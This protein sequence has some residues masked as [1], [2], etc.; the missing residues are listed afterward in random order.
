MS[1]AFLASLLLTQYAP[2]PPTSNLSPR[3]NFNRTCAEWGLQSHACLVDTVRALDNARRKEG[4]GP[5][6]LPRNWTNLTPADQIFVITNLER[7]ARSEHPLPGLTAS[8]NRVA[9]RGAARGTDPIL[10]SPAGP[11]LSIWAEGV[12]PLA[13]DYGWMYDDGWNGPLRRTPNL[14]CT[15]ATATGCWGHRDN[16]LAEWSRRLLAG[17]PGTWYLIAGA[18]QVPT[19]TRTVLPIDRSITED[20][21]AMIVTA[22]EQPPHYV[23]TWAQ[24]VAEG[25]GSA[26][27]GW[28][29]AAV[30]RPLEEA[31]TWIRTHARDVLVGVIVVGL[32]ALTATRQGRRP[33]PKKVYRLSRFRRRRSR[34]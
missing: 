27:K 31:G 21:D 29:P 19:I 33:R 6:Y 32:L 15:S 28:N 23:Y 24:A 17:R 14:A 4:I 30:P 12:G 5:I 7:I 22:V 34:P 20:S 1:F 8:L 9:K 13:S 26:A 11:A 2:P 25:A 16:I 3:P 18:A 10:R